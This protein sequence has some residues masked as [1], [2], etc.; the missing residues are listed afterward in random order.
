MACYRDTFTIA[1]I[2]MITHDSI[3]GSNCI[4]QRIVCNKSLPSYF[5]Q[6][7]TAAL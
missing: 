3:V 1:R 4:D 7:A 6:S 5:L 2:A